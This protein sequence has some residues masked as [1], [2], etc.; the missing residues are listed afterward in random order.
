LEAAALT[1][2]EAHFR[3]LHRRPPRLRHTLQ[4]LPLAAVVEA[5][6]RTEA[7]FISE[8]SKKTALR[9]GAVFLF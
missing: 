1:L 3:A 8:I 4:L 6:A 9:W 2:A 7:F 5:A